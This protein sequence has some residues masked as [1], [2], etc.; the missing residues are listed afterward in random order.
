MSVNA[1]WHN[2]VAQKV[3]ENLNSHVDGLSESESIER[4]EK[5]GLNEIGKEKEISIFYIYKTT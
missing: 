4:L 3:L 2:L 1:K 5:Y